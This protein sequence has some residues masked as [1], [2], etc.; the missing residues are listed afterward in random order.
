MGA[1]RCTLAGQ[2][3]CGMSSGTY[4]AYLLPGIMGGML[5]GG[6]VVVRRPQSRWS[7]QEEAA[8][9]RARRA[10]SWPR[11]A[12][13]GKSPWRSERGQRAESLS[14]P[15]SRA[16]PVQASPLTASPRF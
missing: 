6:V 5:G 14:T 13:A 10:L 15:G 12:L 9:A 7:A 11:P 4:G 8:G 2:A 16:C 1:L 3:R